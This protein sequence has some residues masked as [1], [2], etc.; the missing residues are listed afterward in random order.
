MGRMRL[1][2]GQAALFD[3]DEWEAAVAAVPIVVEAGPGEVG[4]TPTHREGVNLPGGGDEG[5]R[6]GPSLPGS[7]PAGAM[8]KAR[9]NLAAL[10]VLATLRGEGRVTTDAERAILAQ[11]SGW[12]SIPKVFDEADTEYAGIRTALRAHLDDAAWAA[13][14]L[15][16]L[17]AHYTDPGVVQAIWDAVTALGFKGGRVLEPGCGAG[18]FIGA[19][20]ADARMT[21][22][23]LDPTTAAICAALYPGADVRAEGFEASRFARDSFDAAIG[24]V[25]FGKYVLRDL[26]H[27]RGRHS[28]HNHFAIK[29]LALTRPG[30]IVAL[31]T[32]RYALD[33]RNDAARREMAGMADLL[34]AVR[35]PGGA[36]RATAGTDAVMDILVLRRREAGA[37]PDGIAWSSLV[38]LE[39]PGGAVTLNEALI[40][41]GRVL[42]DLRCGQGMYRDDELQVKATGPLLPALSAALASIVDKARLTGLTYAAEALPKAGKLKAAKPVPEP[43]PIPAGERKEGAIII[44]PESPSGFARKVRGEMVTYMPRV[45]KDAAELAAVIGLRDTLIALLEHESQGCPD[46]TC[47]ATRAMLGRRYDAYVAAYGP[48]N[49]FKAHT[50]VDRATGEETTWRARP[51]MGGFRQDDPDYRSVL[52]LEVFDAET[53]AASKAPIF[54]RRAMVARPWAKR[55]ESASDALAISLDQCGRVDLDLIADLLEVSE[56]AEARARLGSMVWDDPATGECV[57][58]RQY[59]SGNVREKLNAALV[60]AADDPRWRPNVEALRAILPPDV[61][62]SDIDAGPGVTWIPPS[63]VEAFVKQVLGCEHPTVEYARVTSTWSIHVDRWARSNVACRSTFGTGRI[64]AVSILQSSANQSAVKVYD[65]VE[66]NGEERQVLNQEETLLAREKQEVLAARFGEWV[67]EDPERA[68]R[69]TTEYNRRFNSIV[70]PE[71]DGSHLTFPGLA[72]YFEPHPHQANAVWRMICDPTVGVFHEVGA[73]KTATATMAIQELKRLGLIRKPL[74][75][76]PN[77]VLDQFAAEYLRLYPLARLLVFDD[78]DATPG[79]RKEFMARAAAGEWDCILVNHSTF[80]LMPMSVETRAEFLAEKISEFEN[81]IAESKD[82]KR[83][84]VKR[85]ELAKKRLEEKLKALL[86]PERKDDGINFE[87]MNVDY[88][89][90]DECDLFKNLMVPSSDGRGG[91]PSQRAENLDMVLTWL[92]RRHP[93]HCAAGMTGT[94]VANTLGEMYVMQHY[95]SP[96]LLAAAGLHSHDAWAATFVRSET[97]LELAPDGRNYRMNTRPSTFV[98]IPELL[99]MFRSFADVKLAEDLKLPVPTIVGGRPA[100]VVVEGSDELRAYIETIVERAERIREGRPAMFPRVNGHGDEYEVEDNMLLVCTDGRKVSLDTRAVGLGA[101]ADGGKIRTAAANIARLYHETAGN[102]YIGADGELAVRRGAL[103]MVFCDLGTPGGSGWNAYEA[104]RRD[105]A[106]AGVPAE[107]VRFIHEAKN[108]AARR[109]LFEACRNGTVSVLVGS[110][111]KMGAGTNVQARLVALHHIDGPWRPREVTQRDGRGVRQGNQNE[112]VYVFR[113]VTEGS[114]DVYIWQTLERKARF[115]YQIMSGKVTERSV[116]DIGEVALSFSEIKALATGNPLILEEATVRTQ[117]ARLARLQRGHERDQAALRYRLTRADETITGYRANIATLTAGATM[118]AD[119]TGDRFA[120]RLGE[121][122]FTDRKLAGSALI[123]RARRDLGVGHYDTVKR[124]AVGVIGGLPLE[125][126]TALSPNGKVVTWGIPDA[127]TS[128]ALDL[129]RILY[130]AD[131]SGLVATLE[132]ALRGIDARRRDAIAMLDEA[133]REREAAKARIGQPFKD[134]ELLAS[135][136]VRAADLTKQLAALEKKPGQGKGTAA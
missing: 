17:N 93:K 43:V 99:T 70:L 123:N 35:L 18:A 61:P 108:D 81:A 118:R 111:E 94:P 32:S 121:E 113:Y 27:N 52:A 60:A 105:L 112:A 29:A 8:A 6:T 84:S 10:D 101:P 3:V 20:P 78:N 9:A 92:R 55:A 54:T 135:L 96:G 44:A 86:N 82:G 87:L 50:R 59:L 73:G 104:L 115:I 100:A 58:A 40:L 57:T 130:G 33:S 63:D 90:I 64:D 41:P 24:N 22:V 71:Y 75:T 91:K 85:L 51:A 13:A 48:L 107:S 12:G 36:M 26:E 53:Q 67:W 102:S 76:C 131:G 129:S 37:E 31:V 77:N 21:G 47:E 120:M 5:T 136:R 124:R 98:N 14:R 7:A 134:A 79:G 19:A 125:L 11:W 42:G 25:P 15:T 132:N 68:G 103:Q 72:E 23:E 122:T 117:V 127:V 30:G 45:K 95:F 88:L 16:V 62:T 126:G 83:L 74:I 38:D 2:R 109:D 110:T 4:S 128:G 34:G 28:I 114:F 56:T 65:T 97:K 106:A 89:V 119:T 49:R 80:N 1:S 133:E 66:I 46:A 116:D 69:L 39:V